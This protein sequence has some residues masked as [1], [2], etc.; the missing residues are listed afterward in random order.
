MPG[1]PQKCRLKI[2]QLSCGRSPE[3][4]RG[5]GDDWLVAL[6]LDELER[7]QAWGRRVILD[8]HQ[9]GLSGLRQLPACWASIVMQF[10]EAPWRLIADSSHSYCNNHAIS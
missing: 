8:L 2:P 1:Y 9:E 5:T 10:T 3:R 7:D 4:A 6:C